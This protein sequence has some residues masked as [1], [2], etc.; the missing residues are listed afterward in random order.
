MVNFFAFSISGSIAI[1]F[2][3]LLLLLFLW[4]FNQK[5]IETKE[6]SFIKE[7]EF[8]IDFLEEKVEKVE[9]KLT[10]KEIQEKPINDIPKKEESASKTANVGVGVNDLFKQ[11]ESKQPVKKEALKPQSTNDKIA[12]KKKA[13]EVSQRD[14]LTDKLDKIMSN[15]EVQKTMSFATPKGE[16]DEFYS[17]IQEILYKNWKPIRSGVDSEA[18]VIITIDFNGRFSYRVVKK[19]GFLEFDN[20]LEEFLDI[21]Q[22]QEFPK[23]EG[24]RKTNIS[25][26]F[27]TEV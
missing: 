14:D 16:Y 2:Y 24:G 27:K 26:I 5:T 7:T 22:R 21:M 17:K 20:A 3:V 9:K 18:E 6:Y 19:S 11:V 23:Y 12:K 15:L 10:I 13:N 8:S 4:N 1:L 25:V